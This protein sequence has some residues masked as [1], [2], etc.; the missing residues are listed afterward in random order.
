MCFN[1]LVYGV[2]PQCVS[3]TRKTIIV[4]TLIEFLI[5]MK[6]NFAYGIVWR[7]G[8]QVYLME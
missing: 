4:E 7:D 1:L 5:V 2:D 6:E 8:Q 3:S